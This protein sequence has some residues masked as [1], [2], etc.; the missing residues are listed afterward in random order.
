MGPQSPSYFT[1]K[2][3]FLTDFSGLKNAG[4]GGRRS[5]LRVV[6]FMAIVHQARVLVVE[7][8][9]CVHSNC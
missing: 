6:F 4:G 5:H 1:F 9:V 8:W 3:Q 2:S 7:L